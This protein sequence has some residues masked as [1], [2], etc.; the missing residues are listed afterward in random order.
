MENCDLQNQSLQPIQDND[1]QGARNP[2]VIQTSSELNPDR[3]KFIILDY[4]FSKDE[5]CSSQFCAAIRIWSTK[6]PK[7][8]FGQA[9]F[10]QQFEFGAQNSHQ[11]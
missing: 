7:M 2:R 10:A 8:S 6:P 5:F 9:N 1:F 4:H 3:V 11:P